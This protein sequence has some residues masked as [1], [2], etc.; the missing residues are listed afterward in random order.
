VSY[1]HTPLLPPELSPLILAGLSLHLVYQ[2]GPL[3]S[4]PQH[5]TSTRVGTLTRWGILTKVDP[6]SLRSVNADQSSLAT[7]KPKSPASSKYKSSQPARYLLARQGKLIFEDENK[8]S[9]KH[10]SNQLRTSPDCLFQPSSQMVLSVRRRLGQLTQ[11]PGIAFIEAIALARAVNLILDSLSPMREGKNEQGNIRNFSWSLETVYQDIRSQHRGKV[12]NKVSSSDTLILEALHDVD[13]WN[14]SLLDFDAILSLWMSAY[15]TKYRQS[16]TGNPRKTLDWLS[17]TASATV[18]YRRVLGETQPSSHNMEGNQIIPDIDT[19]RRR[20]KMQVK[21][22]TLIRDLNWWTD[23]PRLSLLGN[24]CKATDQTESSQDTKPKSPFNRSDFVIGFRGSNLQCA[25]D[26]CDGKTVQLNGKIPKR[27]EKTLKIISA[28]DG[29]ALFIDSTGPLA[30]VMAHH[31]LTAFMWA[32]SPHINPDSFDEAA[33]EDPDLFEEVKFGSTWNLLTLRNKKLTKLAREIADT[34]LSSLEDIFLCIIPP[35]SA[36]G[37]LPSEAILSV[38]LRKTKEAERN[39]D[40]SQ[41]RQIYLC[42]LTLDLDPRRLDRLCY[43]VVVELVEFLFFAMDIL[44]DAGAMDDFPPCFVERQARASQN[45][46]DDLIAAIQEREL[47]LDV[48][49]ELEWFYIR[50]RRGVQF[51]TLLHIFQRTS[52]Y[53]TRKT[54][55]FR[56]EKPLRMATRVDGIPTPSKRLCQLLQFSPLHEFGSL[57]RGATDI[58]IQAGKPHHTVAKPDIFGWYPIHYVTVEGS[59]EQFSLILGWTQKTGLSHYRLQDRSGRTPLH[60]AAMHKPKKIPQL[61]ECLGSHE[62][63]LTAGNVEGRDGALPIHYA[64][65]HG[66]L[67]SLELLKEYSSLGNVDAF[68]RSALHLAVLSCNKGVV[69]YLNDAD[70]STKPT[71]EELLRR[72]PLHF[73]LALKQDDI[74]RALLS[75]VKPSLSVLTISDGQGDTLI[76]LALRERAGEVFDD[77]IKMV[78]KV[79]LRPKRDNTLS[80]PKLCFNAMLKT[81]IDLFHKRAIQALMHHLEGGRR[82]FASILEVFSIAYRL[83][84]LDVIVFLLGIVENQHGEEVLKPVL[85]QQKKDPSSILDG[86]TTGHS[87]KWS[88]PRDRMPRFDQKP[89]PK[90]DFATASVPFS[91]LTQVHYHLKSILKIDESII[92]SWAIRN[93][94]LSIVDRTKEKGLISGAEHVTWNRKDEHN[95]SALGCIAKIKPVL[96]S[97][98]C[99]LTPEKRQ[100]MLEFMWASWKP[101]EKAS[102]LNTTQGRHQKTPLMY[103]AKNCLTTLVKIFVQTGARVEVYDDRGKTALTY[104]F[105][106][107]ETDATEIWTTPVNAKPDIVNENTERT[108]IAHLMKAVQDNRSDVIKFLSTYGQTGT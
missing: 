11:I 69:N 94:D 9:D 17:D 104:A 59:D 52:P 66:Q 103:A 28:E 105:V 93:D 46:F 47:L 3:E 108:G 84:R 42:L 32:V 76:K 83:D 64:A 57:S 8:G 7:H 61:L 85:F 54:D 82:D 88:F 23:D 31:L 2:E 38:L 12:N 19:H 81:A 72:T 44:R 75:R 22:D 20:R 97:G 55:Q 39:H 30:S 74:A 71:K 92:F 68:D 53:G 14:V 36:Q 34:G 4:P 67:E 45:A 48:F 65:R 91:I 15:A 60:Y 95:R 86:T 99:K 89:T 73:A 87:K 51:D 49:G 21:T 24:D 25:T 50:Q 77:M 29:S 101:I 18:T 106:H 100:K 1:K 56:R 70:K 10:T 33:V 16:E 40:W 58:K 27:S 96:P 62:I 37:L 43:K 80:G 79:A 90:V 5:D 107:S 41:A 78:P 35:L 26:G 98:N 6:S 13:G 63:G 102:A